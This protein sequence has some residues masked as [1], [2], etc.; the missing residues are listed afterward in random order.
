[1]I[2]FENTDVEVTLEDIDT[3]YE[4]LDMEGLPVQKPEV[5]LYFNADRSLDS[6][7]DVIM[8]IQFKLEGLEKKAT[9]TVAYTCN[10]FDKS[11]DITKLSDDIYEV[12]ELPDG[13]MVTIDDLY[14]LSKVFKATFTESVV[15]P[16]DNTSKNDVVNK[17]LE[18]PNVQ[19]A[20]KLAKYINDLVYKVDEYKSVHSSWSNQQ[21]RATKKAAAAN[22]IRAGRTDLQM[23]ID[24][25][26]RLPGVKNVQEGKLMTGS[27]FKKKF[28]IFATATKK[29][30]GKPVKVD[31]VYEILSDNSGKH[32]VC[33]LLN[34]S[35]NGSELYSTASALRWIKSRLG[36]QVA[37]IKSDEVT[38]DDAG[39][40]NVKNTADE[41]TRG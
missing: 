24:D 35:F 31:E 21:T 2:L 20:T 8:P 30:R 1:M 18:K 28:R 7:D 38:D 36:M 9:I 11:F 29:V 10:T 22:A 34:D 14:K 40:G 33:R 13:Y 6:V 16:F 3:E 5:V 23:L 4:M 17:Y 41:F 39:W 25:I 32:L 26:K 37:D 27:R 12:E 15:Y 19:L